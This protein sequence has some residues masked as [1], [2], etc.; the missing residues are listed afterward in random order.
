[1]AVKHGASASGDS[2]TSS[3]VTLAHAQ[4]KWI[5]GILVPASCPPNPVLCCSAQP[6]VAP[7]ASY[8]PLKFHL[9]AGTEERQHTRMPPRFPETPSESRGLCSVKVS[10]TCT[11]MHTARSLFVSPPTSRT[12]LCPQRICSACLSTSDSAEVEIFL[13]KG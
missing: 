3:P 1:M 4:I 10:V 11:Q 12:H 5:R 9:C 2:N 6:G 8:H 13:G 7:E